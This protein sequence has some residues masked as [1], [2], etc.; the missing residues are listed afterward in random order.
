MKTTS[1]AELRLTFSNPRLMVRDDNTER[2]AADTQMV[3]T[4]N[5]MAVAQS[6]HFPFIAPIGLLEADD[7]KWYLESYYIWPVGLFKERAE[8]IER[9]FPQWGDK[10]L[11]AI[12]AS[13]SAQP[14]FQQWLDASS[15]HEPVFSLYVQVSD[16]PESKTAASRLLGFPWELLRYH[17]QY[18]LT[19]NPP[20]R[21][22]RNL[23]RLDTS[24]VTPCA[25]NQTVLRVLAV[26]PRPS[27]A[28]YIDHRASI[29]PLV[30]AVESLGKRVELVRVNPPTFEQLKTELRQAQATGNPFHVLHFDGHGVFDTKTGRGA[31]CFEHPL[32][33]KKL[34]PEFVKRIYADDLAALLTEYPLPLVFLE[35][36]QTG[37]SEA[38]KQEHTDPNASV[39]AALLQAGVASVIAMSHSVLVE[40]ARRFV[41]TFYQQ[42]AEGQR[43]GSA[44]LAGRQALM[45]ST[46]RINIAGAGTLHMQDWF[47]PVLYQRE[48][49]PRLFSHALQLP[50][51]TEPKLLLGDLPETPKHTFIG[52]SRDLLKLERLLDRQPYA[53]IRGMGGIGKTAV[54]VELARWLV[55]CR[56]FERC[57][58]VSVE[59][60]TH[61][62]T[63][64]DILGKQLVDEKYSVAEYGNDLDAAL[65]P[66]IQVLQTQRT[67]LV[68]DNMESLLADVGNTEPV[69]ALA[70]KLLK[71][72]LKIRLLFTTRE[73][74]PAPFNHKAYDIELGTL[75]LDD[76]KKLVMQV[77]NNKGL[78]L[79]GDNQN[80]T[81]EEVDALVNSVGCH[82]RALVLLAQELVQTGVSATTENVQ[83]IMIKLAKKHPRNRENSLFASVEL[84]LRRLSSPEVREKIKGLAVF[85]D[86]GRP[87]EIS[88]V[89][90]IDREN[91]LNLLNDLVH[92]GLAQNVG[93]DFFRFDPSLPLYL[94]QNISQKKLYKTKL[95]WIRTN[96]KLVAFIS[97]NA[98]IDTSK[99]RQL[100]ILQ[101]N[102]LMALLDNLELGIK[103]KVFGYGEATGIAS[104]IEQAFEPTT[105]E[106]C[107][108]KARKIR[109]ALT[110]HIKE[111]NAFT[112]QSKKLD[113]EYLL[114]KNKSQ[115][116]YDAAI[117][118]HDLSKQ[119]SK[120]KSAKYDIAITYLLIG[121]SLKEL[122]KYTLALEPLQKAY[123]CFSDIDMDKEVASM[124][125]TSLT[126]Q[127]GCFI[128]TGEYEKAAL[129]Y[130]KSIEINK[131]ILSIRGVATAAFQL[132]IVRLLQ[133]RTDDAL[134]GFST[135][136]GLFE[137]LKEPQSIMKTLHQIGMTY[138]KQKIYIKSEDAYRKALPI[139]S[140][141]GTLMDEADISAELGLLYKEW[142]KHEQAI[143]F[144][145]QA[146]S[147][148]VKYSS[149]FKE[150]RWRTN[151]ASSLISLKKYDEAK[152]EL[153]I[154][155]I[156]CSNYSHEI[157]P[158]KIWHTAYRLHMEEKDLS[159]AHDARKNAIAAFLEYRRK[160]GENY[161]KSG[162][163]FKEVFHAIKQNVASDVSNQIITSDEPHQLM[164]IIKS[165]L[166]GER[167]IMSISDKD[168][169]YDI[170]TE[171]IILL[172]KLNEE[173][174]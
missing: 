61:E 56:R 171:I 84:S 80:N 109:R 88:D 101:R 149:A 124:K 123:E 71:S 146:I 119:K 2:V 125:L 157:E 12:T 58:F 120:Y 37:Q 104:F 18:L 92:I 103:N 73:T 67:L 46:D 153:S 162:I 59:T 13:P 89:L 143:K 168:L 165:I 156:A 65:Q 173:N 4:L 141:Q 9:Y 130:I 83:H 76:A 45:Q 17:D 93:Y 82:A 106:V 43:I 66:I 69:L 134:S 68:I 97:S 10:L 108:Q 138:R 142:G 35:A 34:L 24:S 91:S 110:M 1:S 118:L 7:I 77:M 100:T 102:N 132:S 99:M 145:K 54:A 105:L 70:D 95:S 38:E 167:N 85:H 170:A 155:T 151:L 117:R 19:H 98:S 11:T 30:E 90:E 87:E 79:H 72:S 163:L 6:E 166:A 23:P 172:D 140:S 112:F 16:T 41:S 174:I 86:G 129:I 62:R 47:V 148:A 15:N 49:D 164:S 8:R 116:A 131:K 161:E 52:R 51:E 33:N 160:G 121:R 57:A 127:A 32:D 137:K 122:N 29:K 53:V 154:S 3:F 27:Q 147:I 64:V 55:Q 36:C 158:W 135:V 20:V 14:V 107:Y 40:T 150:Y 22:R 25:Q 81:L 114:K 133:D 126:D 21:I 159:A 5:G 50:D 169:P 128:N 144:Y 74:L 115:A 60:Y 75:S 113:I 44:V 31:L 111:W 28:G 94:R 139:A 48:D 78:S 42:L 26:S 96:V 152:H 39:A 63:I 136:L